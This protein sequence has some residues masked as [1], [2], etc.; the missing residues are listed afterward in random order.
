LSIKTKQVAGV[1]A[2]VGLAVVLL[3]GWYLSSLAQV[4]L[5]ESRARADLVANLISQRARAVVAAGADPA[6]LHDQLRDDQGLR[7]ILEASIL[8]KGVLYAAVVDTGG[9]AIAHSDP[10]SAGD[11]LPLPAGSLAELLDSGP[12]V[13][14]RAIFVE[15]GRTFEIRQPLLLTTADPVGPPVEIG[16][17]RVGVMP[18]LIRRDVTEALQT[19]LLTALAALAGSVIVAM[20][21]AQIV[22]KPIHV[23]RAGLARLGRGEVNVSVDLPDEGELGDLGDSFKAATARLAA[24]RSELAGQRAALESVVEHLEDAVALFAPDGALLFANPPMRTALGADSG[25]VPEM[26]AEGHPYRTA[27]EHTL[28]ERATHGPAVV[29][30]PGAGERLV[31]TNL[32]QDADG[33]LLGVLLVARNLAY[34]S[35][36]ESTLSYS[37]KLAALSRLS[38]G[39]AHEVK[40]PLNA[41]MIHLE[42]LKQQLDGA[43][44]AMKH[45]SVIA[46]Q[47]RRLDEVVQGFLKFTR[48]EELRLQPVALAALFDELMPVI[49]AEAGKHKVD[50][51]LECRRDLPPVSGDP[52]ML[53]QA[54]LNLALNACQAMP[55]GGRLRIAAYTRPGRQIEVVFE[56]TGVGIAPEHL[57]RI[58][59]LYFTTKASGS[60]IGLSM[61]YRTV[62][63]HGGDIEVQSVPGRG[64]TFRVLLRQAISVSSAVAAAPAS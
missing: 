49:R 48:P 46:A 11:A 3:S 60:G 2:I 30:V 45:V 39:I 5:E 22:L 57:A 18:L 40:N 13:Q 50:V 56:D 15:A 36:V 17:I 1:T 33:R 34:L 63:L 4:W 20:L 58:F 31:L 28:A 55:H 16:A 42:L 54:F 6:T 10:A 24:E 25:S 61:V 37:R 29:D 64:S 21:L 32:V 35:Q 12:I 59:D 43:P 7:S 19:P 41:T 9:V 52:G 27:V 23:I 38:A 47:V 53:Q 62:Q 14:L 8:S 26:L 51:R 44:E